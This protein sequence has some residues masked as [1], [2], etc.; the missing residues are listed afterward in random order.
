MTFT[1]FLISLSIGNILLISHQFWAKK[2]KSNNH[3]NT[4]STFLVWQFWFTFWCK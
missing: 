1:N 2:T 4:F 3:S